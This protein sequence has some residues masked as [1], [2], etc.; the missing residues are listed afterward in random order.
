[1]IAGSRA[2]D[3]SLQ[4]DGVGQQ[5]PVAVMREKRENVAVAVPKCEQVAVF[6]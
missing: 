4:P 2:A 3:C 6:N 5:A 1:M